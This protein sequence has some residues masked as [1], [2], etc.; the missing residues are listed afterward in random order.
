MLII[1]Y[2]KILQTDLEKKR[3]RK[4]LGS[5]EAIGRLGL[6]N[7]PVGSYSRLGSIICSSKKVILLLANAIKS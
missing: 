4:K 7:Y 5:S 1:L 6:K 3:G 2:R